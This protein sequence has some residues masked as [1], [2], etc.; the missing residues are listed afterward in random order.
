MSTNETLF[1]Q[2]K[3]EHG[4]NILLN[5]KEIASV[6]NDSEGMMYTHVKMRTGEDITIKCDYKE[7]AS[8][9][10]KIQLSDHK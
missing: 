5:K 1:F 8:Q 3:N 9:L 7:L 2:T 10:M 4:N 6:Y